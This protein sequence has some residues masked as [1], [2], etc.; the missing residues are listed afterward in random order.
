MWKR[1]VRSFIFNISS[2]LNILQIIVFVMSA[3]A[4][5]AE[6]INGSLSNG[7]YSLDDLLAGGEAAFAGSKFAKEFG[8]GSR[9]SLASVIKGNTPL[10]ESIEK[11]VWNTSLSMLGPVVC[12]ARFKKRNLSLTLFV[13]SF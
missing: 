8:E 7:S 6:M 12:V 11:M 3:C 5:Q 13:Y 1:Y 4:D 9:K 10:F 2:L